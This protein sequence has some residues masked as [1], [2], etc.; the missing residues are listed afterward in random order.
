ML[1]L[2]GCDSAGTGNKGYI[3]GAGTVTEVAKADRGEPVSLDGRTLDGQPISLS[4]LRGKPVVINVWWSGCPPCRVEQPKLNEVAKKL[5]S[6][7]H[8]VGINIRD[9]SPDNALA[10]VRSHDV[11]YPSIYDSSGKAL[12]AF[13]AGLSPRTV[14]TTLVLDPQ[15]RVAALIS[16]V[17][18]TELTLLDL[19]DGLKS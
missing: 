15:G 5:G 7:V 11:T 9:S 12:L 4:D 10:Y 8:M 17:V 13:D 18:P 1:V 16:G 19:V 6:S 14:P 2:A 3:D